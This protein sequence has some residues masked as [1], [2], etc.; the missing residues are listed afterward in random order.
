[1]KNYVILLLLTIILIMASFMYKNRLN[2]ILSEFPSITQQETNDGNT[3]SLDLFL[4]FNSTN[5]QDCLRVVNVLNN[6]PKHFRVLGL[7]PKGDLLN[8]EKLRAETG[9]TFEIKCS[10]RYGRFMPYYAPTLIGV[11]KDRRIL[12]VLPSVPNEFNYLK[13]FLENFYKRAYYGL[14]SGDRY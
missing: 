11:S 14:I 13:D 1:M 7:V 12:F 2:R 5:C 10:D 9:A 6:L 3:A 4:V 8:I